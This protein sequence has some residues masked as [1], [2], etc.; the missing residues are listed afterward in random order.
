VLTLLDAII[1]SYE[2]GPGR[3]IPIGNLTSQYFA[4]YYLAFVD[5]YIKETLRIRGYA[6][7][8]D[9]MVLWGNNPRL[10]TGQAAQIDT[11]IQSRLLLTLKP[12]YQN[13][14]STG[15]PFLGFL[16][17]PGGIFLAQTSKRRFIRR[18]KTYLRNYSNGTWN[19]D[20]LA[21]HVNAIIAWTL[22]AKAKNFRYTVFQRYRPR[23][24]TA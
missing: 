17:T 4:N 8:M 2:T 10:L 14:C 5:R 13:R 11:F 24:R 20:R 3:G 1:G 6:R 7:Y 22:I 16:I 15:L 18:Y 9:D 19:I 21:A 12:P 23:A